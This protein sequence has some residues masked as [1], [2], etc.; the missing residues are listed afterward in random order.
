MSGGCNGFNFEPNLMNKIE[1]N[2]LDNLKHKTILSNNYNVYVDPLSELY[3]FNT[4]ID[5]ISEDYS[6][7]NFENKFV[8]K[9]DKSLL[10]TCGCGVSFN[11]K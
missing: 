4:T 10:S 1:F 7:G 8:F 5:Y 2:K 9:V 3:L 6:K 11:I